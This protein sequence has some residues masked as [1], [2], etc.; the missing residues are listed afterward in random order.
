MARAKALGFNNFDLK[1]SRRHGNEP[2]KVLDRK[3]NITHYLE[4]S[5][6][7][8]IKFIRR[9]DFDDYK[10]WKDADKISCYVKENREIYI[11]AN[12]VMLPCCILGSLAFLNIDYNREYYKKHNVYDSV[13]NYDA[14]YGLNESFNQL[15]EELGGYNA[16]DV[17][18]HSIYSIL[19]SNTW[20]QIWEQKWKDRTS[21]CCIKMCSASS[22]FSSIEDQEISS[23][24]L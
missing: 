10:N 21:A 4:A 20:Q 19:S 6:T 17:R 24:K 8:E 23:V 18:Y 3:G 22:P 11:D 1:V 2:F 14:G 15:I 5:T 12:Y 16:L 9:G 7:S 13:S